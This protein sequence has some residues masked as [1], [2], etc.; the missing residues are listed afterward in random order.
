MPVEITIKLLQN[1]MHKSEVQKFLIDGFPR[2]LDN[3]EESCPRFLEASIFFNSLC[4]QGW[5]RVVGE[6]ADVDFCLFYGEKLVLLLGLS[7]I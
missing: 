5:V 1:A 2:S 6:S 7:R 4:L 3:Y